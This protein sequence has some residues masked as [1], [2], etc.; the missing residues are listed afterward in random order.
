M[1][2]KKPMYGKAVRS[3]SKQSVSNPVQVR[4]RFSSLCT[5]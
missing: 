5:P 2:S 4:K 3:S 1:S